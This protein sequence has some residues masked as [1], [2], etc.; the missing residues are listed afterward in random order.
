MNTPKP[1]IRPKPGSSPGQNERPMRDP[2]S[3]PEHDPPPFSERDPG[4]EQKAFG[5]V[6]FH[7]DDCLR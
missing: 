5:R 3:D 7:E 2:P 6:I 1:R 4:A